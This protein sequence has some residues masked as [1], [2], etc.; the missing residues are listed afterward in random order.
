VRHLTGNVVATGDGHTA[1]G[2][3]YVLVYTTEKGSPP[4]MRSSGRY[5]DR[6]R[7]TPEGWR[8]AERRYSSDG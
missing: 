4:S 6:L 7:R 1:T 3:A 8:F 2:A 5:D